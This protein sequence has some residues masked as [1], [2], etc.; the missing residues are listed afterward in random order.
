MQ[1]IRKFIE[2]NN[3]LISDQVTFIELKQRIAKGDK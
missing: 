1:E 3:G 2:R